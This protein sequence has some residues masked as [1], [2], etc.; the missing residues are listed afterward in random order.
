MARLA[1]HTQPS[2]RDVEEQM[3]A[4]DHESALLIAEL[5]LQDAL[6]LSASSKG[7]A[8]VDAPEAD[9]EIALR[10][11]VEELSGWKQT[12]QD[13]AMAESIDHALGLDARIIGA[14]RMM[15]ETAAADRRAAELLQQG[16][17][18]PRPTHAQR[19]VGESLNFHDVFDESLNGSRSAAHGR[20]RD[21][22]RRVPISQTIPTTPQG[23]AGPSV[24]RLKRVPCVSCTDSF[25][26]GDMLRGECGDYWC[27]D[28][29][30]SVMEVYIRDES[31]HPL[32]CCQRSL[33]TSDLSRTVKNR[34]VLARF[35]TK[36]REY[37]VPAQDRVYCS[38]PTCST[39]LGSAN[40]YPSRQSLLGSRLPGTATCQSCHTATCVACRKG[41]HPG[42]TCT[43]NDAVN[44][45][46][47]LA[48]EAGWQTCP[49]C[50]AVIELH[51]GCYHMTCRCR[52]EFCYTCGVR[53]KNC[54]CPQWDE[55][56]LVTTAEAREA[57]PEAFAQQLQ[58]AVE[59]IRA[60][61]GCA[62]HRWV[63]R[64]GGGN[65][66]ECGDYMPVF[67]KMC[68]NCSLMVCRRCSLNRL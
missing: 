12:H 13:A 59:N 9:Q 21:S 22:G 15:E 18:L 35:D 44:Q 40:A 64:T 67:L 31:L 50:S 23:I 38:R 24:D 16:H 17:S 30:A 63:G 46:R 47:A 37:E 8:R 19:V 60:N 26:I 7:K 48:Q 29:L 43:Q 65:C 2:L 5:Q 27:G 1:H 20:E 68:R 3:F 51:H 62:Q 52:T 4:I 54:T 45:V 49:G 14:Y 57:R 39:F 10:L 66:E 56:R 33:V 28:C 53:W 34:A 55:Q 11:Q 32:R 6:A 41:E 61:H 36:R 25:R 42:D 58:R